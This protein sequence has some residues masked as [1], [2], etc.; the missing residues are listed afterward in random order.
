MQKEK[1]IFLIHIS[2]GRNIIICLIL[3][4]DELLFRSKELNIV[5]IL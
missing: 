5:Q 2:S 4:L 1:D 3:R